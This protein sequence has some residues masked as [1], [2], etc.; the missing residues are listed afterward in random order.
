[1]RAVADD[2][3][4]DAVKIGMLGTVETIEAVGG[5]R[6]TSCRV[7]VVLDPVMV[8]ESGARLLDEDAQE[9]L[10]RCWCRA[11]PS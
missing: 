9:A 6:S 3:G 10:G 8:A 4:V 7:P 2:I 1:M 5:R 11:R